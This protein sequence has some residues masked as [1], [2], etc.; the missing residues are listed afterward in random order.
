MTRGAGAKA[1]GC[2][3]PR[4]LHRP[5]HHRPHHHRRR[6][7]RRYCRHRRG[8]PARLYPARRRCPCRARR[9]RFQ[10]CRPSHRRRLLRRSNRWHCRRS[11]SAV[12]H[13]QHCGCVKTCCYCLSYWLRRSRNCPRRCCQSQWAPWAPC[14]SQRRNCWIARPLP[15]HELRQRHL[16]APKPPREKRHGMRSSGSS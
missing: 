6:Q 8:R 16:P 4:C 10:N 14:Q 13:R 11:R 7:P 2:H 12:A 9:G 15:G 1:I 5:R 3:L